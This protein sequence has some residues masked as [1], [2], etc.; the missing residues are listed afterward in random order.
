MTSNTLLERL[1][2]GPIVGDGAM[3]TYL[4][5]LGHDIRDGAEDLV[6]SDPDTVRRVHRAYIEAGAELLE[7]NTFAANRLA[8]A[9]LGESFDVRALNATA[10]R[11]AHEAAAGR[12]WVAGAVGPIIPRP[13]DHFT[14]SELLAMYVEQVEGLC[15]GGADALIFETFTTLDDLLLAL[16]A[17]RQVAGARLPF[18]AQL[19][20]G[21]GAAASGE[22]SQEAAARL[23]A[24]GADV[25]GANCGRGLQSMRQALDGLLAAANERGYVSL[26]PNAGYPELIG[27][28]T[29]YMGTPDY[30]ARQAAQWARQGVRLIGGCCG[31]T[32]ETIRAIHQALA[33]LRKIPAS[34]KHVVGRSQPATAVTSVAT[35]QKTPAECGGFLR[36]VAD[37]KLPVIAEIDSPPHLDWQPWA[38]GARALLTAGASAISLAEN[39]LASVR[40]EN[41][42]LAAWLRRETGRQVICHMTCRDRN[43]L[44]LQSALMAAHAADIEAV[45]AVTGDPVQRGGHQRVMAVYEQ[46]S[47]GLVRLMTA[48]NGGRN[49]SGRDLKGT[50]DFSIGVAYNSAAANLAAES[51]KL[52]RKRDAGAHFVMTQPVYDLDQ[53][54]QVLEQTATCGMRIFL[55]FLPPVTAKLAH[56]LH[57]EVPGIRLNQSLLEQIDSYDQPGDQQK[58][59]LDWTW[60]LIDTLRQEMGGVY[61]ITPGARWRALLPLLAQLQEF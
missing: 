21:G 36:A 19:V 33:G 42:F 9:P 60:Q 24:A 26:Y 1:A 22:S 6:I 32:P 44:G 34:S 45:L 54:R 43:S 20:Y 57:N 13:D 49:A 59:A 40:M 51:D 48:L 47:V 39:P 5:E 16:Q 55:G 17:G 53:A 14:D 28:R 30:M 50:T 52:R 25:V 10:V 15:E 8:L 56:Y 27:G 35:K 29:V 46:T 3:G 38:E 58:L 11:L 23:L 7:S 2:E 12:T 41:T 31:T 4:H 37:V 18:I 61:L